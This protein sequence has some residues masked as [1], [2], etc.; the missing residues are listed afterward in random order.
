MSTEQILSLLGGVGLFLYGMT[1]M[2][3]GIRKA[4]GAHLHD[5]LE[6]ATGSKLRSVAVGTGLTVL[7][8]SSSATDV[9]VIGF[10]NSG[11]LTLS[12][13]IGVILGANIGTTVTAQITAFNIGLYAPA[14]V[15]VGALVALFVKKNVVKSIGTFVLGFGMLFE[16]VSFM[17]GA[18]AP[19]AQQPKFISFVQALDNPIL[20]ILF[21]VA[22]TML[23]QSSSSATVIFQAFA[24]E[25]LISYKAAV[26]LVIGSAVGS[27]A[28]NL[29]ASLTTNRNGKRTAL[30]NLIFN[31]M[32]AALVSVI[33]VVFPKTLEWIQ[34]LSPGDVARQVA[35]THTILAVFSVAVLLP[36]SEYIVKLTQKILPFQED[37]I[38]K[39]EE[40]R[41][42][43]MLD[44]S[45]VPPA[46]ALKQAKKEIVRMSQIA[47]K[48]LE[49][50]LECLFEQSPEKA[51]RVEEYEK[52]MD[53]LDKAIIEKLVE[54]RASD[55]SA[56]DMNKVYHM[57]LT[58]SDLERISDLSENVAEHA[59]RLHEEHVE[60]SEGGKR[61]L[62][63]MAAE[64][65]KAVKL[66]L[67]I[68]E[69]KQFERLPEAEAQEE[70]V[71]R[72]QEEIINA[73]VHRLVEKSCQPL[74]GVVFTD[75]AT[76]LERCAD[77]A[78]NV[79][80]SLSGKEEKKDQESILDMI[81]GDIG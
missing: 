26:F 30:L 2:S 52:V 32:R 21:G 14:L 12:Q 58:V 73:H 6:K 74:A 39:M 1:L 60:F 45:S 20:L 71:D 68:F 61:D 19:L 80:Y 15:F 57:T 27:V 42:H 53:Y 8:Q 43:Y 75:M 51:K 28:P 16:G 18:I 40:Y 24:V 79:A 66:C 70:I 29:L 72:T 81:A 23:L 25:A 69:K 44:L 33:I 63:K 22:F 48:N 46:V 55:M 11:F 4:C 38:R 76:E 47:A 13:A 59:M 77:H 64:T 17:K 50:A 67:E 9:M 36:F 3:T 31:L 35:N 41:L 78:I 10:V 34:A 37:E 56:K 62:E 65:L 7:V 54:L 49:L 5:I